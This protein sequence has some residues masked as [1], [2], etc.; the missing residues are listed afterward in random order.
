MD[1]MRLGIFRLWREVL[2]L[3]AQVHTHKLF[4][5]HLL[6]LLLRRLL[7]LLCLMCMLCQH[8]LFFGSTTALITMTT[9]TVST[10]TYGLVCRG[11]VCRGLVSGGDV[12]CRRSNRSSSTCST[13]NHTIRLLHM[14]EQRVHPNGRRCKKVWSWWRRHGWGELVELV[15]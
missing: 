1:W 9:C 5:P 7:C 14:R 12:W 11:L 2:L 8:L 6:L 10:A 13:S 15:G 4:Q 3:P